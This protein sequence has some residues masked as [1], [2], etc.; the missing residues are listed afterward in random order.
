MS[1]E[2]ERCCYC[3]EDTLNGQRHKELMSLGES[4]RDL[5]LTMCG[6]K[7]I[8]RITIEGVKKPVVYCPCRDCNFEKHLRDTGFCVRERKCC[9]VVACCFEYCELRNK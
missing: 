1:R 5:I 3:S 6:R 9:R 2:C 8:D 7:I 4:I